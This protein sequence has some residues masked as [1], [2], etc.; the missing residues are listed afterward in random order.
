[1]GPLLDLR[2]FQESDSSITYTGNNWTPETLGDLEYYGGSVKHSNIAGESA[3]FTCNKC[4]YLALV[5][6]KDSDSGKIYV[7]V[8]GGPLQSVDL[9]YASAAPNEPKRK[10]VVFSTGWSE[11]GGHTITVTVR[12][13]KN[14]ASSGTRVDID[15]FAAL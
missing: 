5:S 6:R 2:A 3:T 7:S 10:Y 11:P 12:G 8:D 13:A 14:S 4:R 15:A 1:M 9:Y